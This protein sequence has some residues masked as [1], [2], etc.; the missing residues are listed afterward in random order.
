M[1]LKHLR[2]SR[3]NWLISEVTFGVGPMPMILAGHG[4]LESWAIL[5]F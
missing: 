5:A 4:M 3:R 2:M 1:P